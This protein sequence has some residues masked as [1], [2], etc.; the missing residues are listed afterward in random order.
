MKRIGSV[1][2]LASALLLAGAAAALAEDRP[3]TNCDRPVASLTDFSPSPNVTEAMP[4]LPSGLLQP[5]P[6]W[7]GNCVLYSRCICNC[8]QQG[9]CCRN[10]CWS[11]P[12]NP[13]CTGDCY[14]AEYA[15]E[16][17]CIER[18]VSDG[19]VCDTTTCWLNPF[20]NAP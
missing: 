14:D 2:A 9:I 5:A 19:T 1:V 13:Y 3:V 17:V 15:C 16:D 10:G 11:Q 12:S 20:C 7:M 4:S 8:Q 6:V 18:Y